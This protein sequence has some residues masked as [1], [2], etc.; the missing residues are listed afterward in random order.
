MKKA[1]MDKL[2]REELAR[3]PPDRSGDRQN[4]SSRRLRYFYAMRRKNCLKDDPQ[5]S[6]VEPFHKAVEDVRK[7]DPDFSPYVT[8]PEYFGWR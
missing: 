4:K 3:I 7:T 8:K 1:E 2:I 6:P 5:Q